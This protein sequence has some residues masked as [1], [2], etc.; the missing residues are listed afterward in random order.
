[1]NP[2]YRIEELH[3]TGWILVDECEGLSIEV[4]AQ[5]LNLLIEQGYNPNHL[6][7]VSDGNPS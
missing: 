2:H 5:K 7:A 3:T 6:R 4:A 1:M